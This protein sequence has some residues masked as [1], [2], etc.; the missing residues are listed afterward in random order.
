MTYLKIKNY[1][2]NIIGK[3]KNIYYDSAVSYAAGV[4]FIL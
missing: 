3:I 2:N 4:N 1:Q